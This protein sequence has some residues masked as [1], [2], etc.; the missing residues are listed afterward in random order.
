MNPKVNAAQTG[1]DAP[2]TRG[3]IHPGQGTW[4]DGRWGGAFDEEEK[5]GKRNV[6]SRIEPLRAEGKGM[7]VLESPAAAT[8]ASQ[9][10]KKI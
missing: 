5:T 9:D 2:L 6:S 1:S 7:P 10:P 3:G 8:P 4:K